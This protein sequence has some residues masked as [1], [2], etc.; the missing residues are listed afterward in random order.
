MKDEEEIKKQLLKIEKVND[1]RYHVLEKLIKSA[2]G[3]IEELQAKV[4][5]TTKPDKDT[6]KNT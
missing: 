4:Y 5:G 6:D 3:Y 1:F 2:Y